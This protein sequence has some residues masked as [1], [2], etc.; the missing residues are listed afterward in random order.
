MDK[1]EEILTIL[2]QTRKSAREVLRASEMPQNEIEK[3]VNPLPDFEKLLPEEVISIYS[4]IRIE[5]VL[6]LH[7]RGFSQR[8]IAKRMGGSTQPVMHKIL[9]IHRPKEKK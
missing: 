3:V 1:Q 5:M 2:E 7:D 8:E 4:R 6:Y 9:K